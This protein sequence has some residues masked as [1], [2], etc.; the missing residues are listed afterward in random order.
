MSFIDLVM[1]DLPE[2][3]SFSICLDSK[4]HAASKACTEWAITEKLSSKMLKCL[5]VKYKTVIKGRT[6]DAMFSTSVS[7]PKINNYTDLT[8]TSKSPLAKNLL[9]KK[10]Q[11]NQLKTKTTKNKNH[12]MIIFVTSVI[13]SLC[14]QE[15]KDVRFFFRVC[16]SE[17]A[18]W[19]NRGDKADEDKAL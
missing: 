4:S 7:C 18:G 15:Q 1:L 2:A 3:D 8:S 13:H 5:N 16:H 11:Q 10:K 17:D 6:L 9:K 14:L 19:E 12:R